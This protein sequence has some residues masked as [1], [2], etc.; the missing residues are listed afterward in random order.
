MNIMFIVLMLSAVVQ[1]IAEF[2]PISSSGHLVLLKQIEW[3]RVVIEG[4]GDGLSMLI[5]VALHVATL[6]SVLIFLWKDILKLIVGFFKAVTER[7]FSTPE[8]K[9]SLFIITASLPVG[10][11]GFALK[12]YLY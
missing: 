3:F 12:D 5:D 8:A 10:V 6:I 9:T 4:N 2:L 1:G 7:D 11:I